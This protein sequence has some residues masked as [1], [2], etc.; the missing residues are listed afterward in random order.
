[1]SLARLVYTLFCITVLSG[2]AYANFRGYVP[3]AVN[4]TSAKHSATAS[5]FHK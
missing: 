2:L 5:R 3:F 4:A 1:M